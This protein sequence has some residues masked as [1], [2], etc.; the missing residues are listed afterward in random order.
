MELDKCK[1]KEKP[2]DAFK[3]YYSLKNDWLNNKEEM[4]KVLSK[5]SNGTVEA[6]YL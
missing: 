6:P 2:I 4:F 3:K 5:I 1:L